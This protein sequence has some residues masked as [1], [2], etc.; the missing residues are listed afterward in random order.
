MYWN[1]AAKPVKE[2]EEA[3][4]EHHTTFQMGK[5][6]ERKYCAQVKLYGTLWAPEYVFP[7]SFGEDP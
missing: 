3:E 4:N 1:W 2:I 5:K 7:V 6:R